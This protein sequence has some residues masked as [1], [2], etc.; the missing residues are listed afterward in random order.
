MGLLTEHMQ[1]TV[2]EQLGFIAT[3]R[4]DGTPNLSPKGTTA[5]WDDDHLIFAHIRSPGTV[6][7]LRVNPN[8][9]INVVDQLSR[10]GYRFSG[11]ASVHE[12]GETFERGVRF[13]QARGTPQAAERIRAVVIIE[14]RRVS[15][16]T[17][18]AYDLGATEAEL[19]DIW[20][21]RIVGLSRA[22]EAGLE[23]SDATT[24]YRRRAPKP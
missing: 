7:N 14:V 21:D 19:R 11:V 15:R 18:P 24:G 9:E 20:L 3:V 8:I 4:P 16:L 13:Y 17:S 10:T 5:V 23:T 12:A 1:H 22:P 6:A 2:E